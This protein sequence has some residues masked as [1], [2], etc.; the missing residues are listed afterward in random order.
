M[1]TVRPLMETDIFRYLEDSHAG[2]AKRM[3]A[4]LTNPK[5]TVILNTRM[6]ETITK[7]VQTFKEPIVL[8]AVS[9]IRNGDLVLFYANPD[10]NLPECMP[11]FRYAINGGKGKVAVNLT[12]VASIAGDEKDGYYYVNDMRKLYCMIIGA[13]INLKVPDPAEYPIKTMEFG[14][15]TWAKHFCKILNTTIGLSTSRDRYAAFFYFAARFYLT[16][17]VGAPKATVDS[18][19]K[20]I[21]KGGEGNAFIDAIQNS[22][23]TPEKEAS[24]YGSFTGFCTVLFDNGI[25]NTKALRMAM[26]SPT[27]KLNMSF[28]LRK[29]IDSYYQSAILSLAS[30]HYFTWLLLCVQKRAFLVN[31]KMLGN[32]FDSDAELVKYFSSLYTEVEARP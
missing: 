1:A 25:T 17:Y 16:Y 32:V 29:Y 13:Y 6:E 30:A 28:Y 7:F 18:I 2:I 26:A 20:A 3:K 4:I 14:A 24:F 21:L 27:E 19:S 31:I 5:A 9:A 11:F 22:L 10:V 15:I 23:D 8:K 12:N